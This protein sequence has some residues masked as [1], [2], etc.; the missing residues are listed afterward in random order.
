MVRVTL[1]LL[2]CSINHVYLFVCVCVCICCV[3]IVCVCLGIMVGHVCPE[4]SCGGNIAL[5]Q[6]G[7]IVTVDPT[8]KT[9][10]VVSTCTSTKLIAIQLLN[11]C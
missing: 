3:A 1:Q 6:N 7:D 9:L 8:N 10:D 4:A 5:I 2:F 11:T